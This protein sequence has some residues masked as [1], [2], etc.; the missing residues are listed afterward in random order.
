MPILWAICTI[1]FIKKNEYY[2]PESIEFE[3][4]VILFIKLPAPD[5]DG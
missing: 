2:E 4:E 3:T 5:D 1:V